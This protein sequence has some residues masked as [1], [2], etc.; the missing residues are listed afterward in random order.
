M[1]YIG[2]DVSKATLDCAYRTSQEVTSQYMTQYINDQAGFKQIV[3]DINQLNPNQQEVFVTIEP[4][5]GYES[6]CVHHLLAQG[7][8][9]SLPNPKFIKDFASSQGRRS[10]TDQIDAKVICNYGYERQPKTHTL[11][12]ANVEEMRD[13]LQRKTD[14][15]KLIRAEKNR[16]KQ[17]QQRPR[18]SLKVNSSLGRIL[19][20]LEDELVEIDQ[21][22]DNIVKSEATISDHFKRL[23][24][25][26][27]IG[28][29]TVAY[30]FVHL[31][32]CH[33]LT[34]GKGTDRMVVAM[35]GLDP[36]CF[37]SGTSIYLPPRISKKGNKLIRQKL[38]MGALGGV[39]GH[40]PLRDFYQRLVGRGK[41]KKKALVAAMRKILV[42]AWAIFIKEV[43]FDPALAGARS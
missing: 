40:N 29:K 3:A 24:T 7:Y 26:P 30:L 39:S 27:G 33:T 41:A 23:L 6:R 36:E 35:A 11:L 15:E 43:D 16:L 38:F 34:D 2:I 10:K 1:F 37:A 42:W 18:Q 12:A 32:L 21:A 31:T 17:Y 28:P 8:Q 22:L 4:T 19:E 9:V 20:A 5:G 25:L 14:L 13:L